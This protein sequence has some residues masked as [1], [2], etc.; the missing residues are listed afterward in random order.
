MSLRL[1]TW[2]VDITSQRTSFH[3]PRKVASDE[4]S[5]A[6]VR[7]GRKRVKTQR[8]KAWACVK[9]W[10]AMSSWTTFDSAHSFPFLSQLDPSSSSNSSISR[11]KLASFRYQDVSARPVS[12]REIILLSKVKNSR[13]SWTLLST[14]FKFSIISDVQVHSIMQEVQGVRGSRYYERIIQNTWKYFAI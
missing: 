1:A 3:R 7:W 2:T 11:S 14:N 4:S 5:S 13:L 12:S 8:R 9:S 10:S 6:D